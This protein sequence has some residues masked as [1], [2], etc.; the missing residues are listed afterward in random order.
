MIDL[1]PIRRSV[2]VQ[3][4]QGAAFDLFFRRMSEWWPL[5]TRSLLLERA[6]SCHVE[7]RVGGRIYE[8]GRDKTEI[9]WGTILLW[10]APSRVIYSWHPGM[11]ESKATEVEVT[12]TPMG[13]ATRVDFEHRHWERAGQDAMRIRDLHEIGWSA[14]LVRFAE[15]A[16]GKTQLSL[17]ADSR[18][19]LG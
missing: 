10:A 12:F 19:E 9:L 13:A 16:E 8:R 11:D 6:D 17:D 2:V 14:V 15:R 18:C 1:S 4:D 5:S 7:P 3:L